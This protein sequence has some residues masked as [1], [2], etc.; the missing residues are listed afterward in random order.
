MCLAGFAWNELRWGR[1]G[2][3]ELDWGQLGSFRLNWA[4]M[5]SAVLRFAGMVSTGLDRAWLGLARVGWNELGW[6]GL[7]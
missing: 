3:P 1:L 4:Y 7:G 6:V 5:G 2:S